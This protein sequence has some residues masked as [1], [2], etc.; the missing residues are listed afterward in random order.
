[1]LQ[2]G[3]FIKLHEGRMRFEVDGPEGGEVFIELVQ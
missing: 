1:M 2:S 3:E